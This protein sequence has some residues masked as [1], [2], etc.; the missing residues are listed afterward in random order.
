MNSLKVTKYETGKN[1]VKNNFVYNFMS[2]LRQKL[3][4]L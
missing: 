1:Y 4:T 3:M 2:S